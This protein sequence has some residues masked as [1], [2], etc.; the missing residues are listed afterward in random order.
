VSSPC[1]R[2]LLCGAINGA[3]VI[4]GRLQPIVATIA[5]GAI[6]FGLALLLSFSGQFGQ[7]ASRM[8]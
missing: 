6:Y 3:I 5:T 1:W 7:Q 2:R 4:Y 8:P